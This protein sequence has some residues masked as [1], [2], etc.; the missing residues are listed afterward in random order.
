MCIGSLKTAGEKRLHVWPS[1]PQR[2]EDRW[3]TGLDDV[4]AA[5]SNSYEGCGSWRQF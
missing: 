2:V 5:D 1:V 4:A 3:I